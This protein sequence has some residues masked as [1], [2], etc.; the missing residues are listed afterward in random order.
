MTETKFRELLIETIRLSDYKEKENLLDLM[1]YTYVKFKKT[2]NFAAKE[3]QYKE[4]V[5]I[6]IF[7][8]YKKELEKHQRF[9]ESTC[10]E[11][12]EETDEYNICGVEIKPGLEIETDEIRQEIQFES[13]QNRIVDEIKNAK[14]TIWIAVAWFTNKKIFNVLCEKRKE[15][16]NIRLIINDDE[17]NKKDNIDFEGN[18]ETLRLKSNGYY[19][20]I[21]HNKFCVID[22]RTVI[23]GSY[24]WTNKAEYNSEDIAIDTNR[25]TAVSYTDKFMKLLKGDFK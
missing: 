18:F 6:K 15:G 17:I 22:L 3:W 8:K 20:N 7:P 4:Y 16:V 21:M 5:Y 25:A 24:N 14:Y 19:N 12:Y 10:R 13:I 9:I 11:I 23:H 2:T 1:S